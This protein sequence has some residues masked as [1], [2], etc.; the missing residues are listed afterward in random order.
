MSRGLAW[1]SLSEA[2]R[3]SA[4]GIFTASADTLF[5]FI[6][7]LPDGA[8]C[9]GGEKTAKHRKCAILSE[10]PNHKF[11]AFPVPCLVQGLPRPR[12]INSAGPGPVGREFGGWNLEFNDFSSFNGPAGPGIDVKRESGLDRARPGISPV[13]PISSLFLI[14]EFNL[15]KPFAALISP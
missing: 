12:S 14:D 13:L 4:R 15:A 8:F 5:A 2:P 10:I 7:V 9:E 3:A 11:P 1:L 6:P